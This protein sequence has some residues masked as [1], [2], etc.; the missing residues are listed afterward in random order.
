MLKPHKYLDLN[1]SLVKVT[2]EIIK[3][4]LEYKTIEY[5]DLFKIIEDNF[6][7]DGTHLFIPSLNFLFLLG[8]IEYDIET[9]V[10]ELLT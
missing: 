3:V 8:K 6:G 5:E 4:L 10:L 7:L 1:K 9:D 2:S